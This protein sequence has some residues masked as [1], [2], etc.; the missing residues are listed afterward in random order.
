MLLQNI[1][2]PLGMY[3]ELLQYILS[4]NDQQGS[5]IREQSDHLMCSSPSIGLRKIN[6]IA[7]QS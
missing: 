3:Q 6:E 4:S 2:E 1:I 7:F 5:K